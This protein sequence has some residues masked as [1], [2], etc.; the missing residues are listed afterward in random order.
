VNEEERKRNQA[1]K[2]VSELKELMEDELLQ[3][4]NVVGVGVGLRQKGGVYTDEIALVVMVRKKVPAIELEPE[5]RIPEAIENVP[6]DVLEV[7]EL[8][9]G[10]EAA[11]E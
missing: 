6:I 11:D 10:G 1:I 3:K 2:R 9:A 8:F 7:G 5:D 4:P